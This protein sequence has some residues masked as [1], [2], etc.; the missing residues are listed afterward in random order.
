MLTNSPC[1]RTDCPPMDRLPVCEQAH[2]NFLVS[3]AQDEAF[4]AHE[5]PK[6]KNEGVATDPAR[7]SNMPSL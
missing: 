2:T 4:K 5:E 3:T 7:G 6:Q 1:Y